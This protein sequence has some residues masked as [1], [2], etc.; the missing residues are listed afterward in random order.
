MFSKLRDIHDIFP[1]M[2]S[3]RRN[4]SF[5]ISRA[6]LALVVLATVK[7]HK[8]IGRPGAGYRP[9]TPCSLDSG[10]VS[11]HKYAHTLEGTDWTTAAWISKAEHILRDW[12]VQF[13]IQYGSSACMWQCHSGTRACRIPLDDII[14]ASTI[15][16]TQ[17]RL[18]ETCV[19]A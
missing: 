13:Q 2:Q 6:I 18:F 14:N 15:V 5:Q 8:Q 3:V 4:E 12:R 19:S 16:S 9:A 7:P 11:S 1:T 17:Q 10:Y